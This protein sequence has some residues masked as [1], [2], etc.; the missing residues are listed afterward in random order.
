MGSITEDC[1]PMFRTEDLACIGV[2]A[3]QR[4][5]PNGLGASSV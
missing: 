2:F 4:Q 1:E 3:V 5:G